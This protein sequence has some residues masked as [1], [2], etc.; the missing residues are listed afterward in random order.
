M[1]H[2]RGVAAT[3]TAADHLGA[4]RA[5]RPHRLGERRTCRHDVVDDHDPSRCAAIRRR[6]RRA[7]KAPRDVRHA[8]PASRS[9]PRWS[10]VRR[11]WRS[12]ATAAAPA[13]RS[14]ELGHPVAAPADTPHARWA[15]APPRQPAAPAPLQRRRRAP[16]PVRAASP[17]RPSSLIARRTRAGDTVEREPAPHARPSAGR[18]AA[19]GRQQRR[20][21]VR[22][23]Q[24]DVGLVAARAPDRQEERQRVGE[25]RADEI[26][27]HASRR[28][29][30][31]G[32]PGRRR[33]GAEPPVRWRIAATPPGLAGEERPTA[34]AGAP[35]CV[36]STRMP[37]RGLLPG[38]AALDVQ[39]AV[40]GAQRARP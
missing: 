3:A 33:A 34:S 6:H 1:C 7:A 18:L 40:L 5:Q 8:T 21:A 15:S 32:T 2:A 27:Q 38:R 16:G 37:E 28:T 4:R 36:A 29:L 12:S 19:P 35:C 31:I 30:V 25:A 9:R 14:E 13:R 39:R 26:G 24:R 23:A 17:V 10:A 22:V 20:S 11:A